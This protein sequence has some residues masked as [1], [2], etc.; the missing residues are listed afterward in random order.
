MRFPEVR[1]GVNVIRHEFDI[2]AVDVVVQAAGNR[3]N[4]VVAFLPWIQLLPSDDGLKLLRDQIIS[5]R[6]IETGGGK[7]GESRSD[8]VYG[9]CRQ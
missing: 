7:V 6:Y 8:S 1:P 3:V 2:V 9:Y 4:T 5:S